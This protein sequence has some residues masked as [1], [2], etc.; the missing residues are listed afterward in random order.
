MKILNEDLKKLEEI[1]KQITD[2]NNTY[3]TDNMIEKIINESR[4]LRKLLDKIFEPYKD[5]KVIDSIDNN[6]NNLTYT[7]LLKYI[8]MFDY[9]ILDEEIE[10]ESIDTIIASEKESGKLDDSLGMYLSEIGNIPL[11]TPEEE[12]Q[13]FIKYKRNND[14]K[15]YKKLCESNLRLVVSVAKRYTG[16]GIDFMDLIQEGNIGLINGIKKFDLSKNCKLST[17]ATWWIR[18]SISRY[19]LNKGRMIRI[20]VHLIEAINKIKKIKLEYTSV[21]GG[22][23]PTVEELK[24]ISGFSKNVIEKCLLYEKDAISFDE[25]VGEMNQ[26]KQKT[27]KDFIPDNSISLEEKIDKISL[28][29]TMKEVLLELDNEL[30]INVIKMRFGLDGNDPKTIRSIAKEC[31]LMPEKIQQIENKALRKLRT[32][33]NSSKLREYI[34]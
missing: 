33:K 23:I 12:K 24:K 18:Q 17:Y 15:A 16:L 1:T 13:L 8:Y 22:K 10:I 26:G 6:F 7:I 4:P 2:S 29:D 11:L 34:K 31:N 25:P 28:K 19:I 9:V 20:P 27:L 32:P 3:I 21:N 30:E 14:I 5:K